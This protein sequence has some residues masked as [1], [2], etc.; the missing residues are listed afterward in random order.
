LVFPRLQMHRPGSRNGDLKGK[1]AGP[2][3]P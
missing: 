2:L 3:I 1:L